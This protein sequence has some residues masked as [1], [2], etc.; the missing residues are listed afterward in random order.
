MKTKVIILLVLFSIMCFAQPV[1]H[2]YF[3]MY[4]S[5]FQ[6]MTWKINRIDNTS[7]TETWVFNTNVYDTIRPTYEELKYVFNK[8]DNKLSSIRLMFWA[9]DSLLVVKKLNQ[10]A[11][12]VRV[13]GVSDFHPELNTLS[14]TQIQ[15]YTYRIYIAPDLVNSAFD[16]RLIVNFMR[17]PSMAYYSAGNL[18]ATTEPYMLILELDPSYVVPNDPGYGPVIPGQIALSTIQISG[19]IQNATHKLNIDSVWASKTS[20]PIHGPDK[21]TDGI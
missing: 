2:E 14:S 11:S 7:L 9:Y 21:A 3:G 16:G 10:Y 19:Y 1:K 8:S 17:T 12:I 5:R 15:T 4:K 20:E 13:N 18:W 6:A